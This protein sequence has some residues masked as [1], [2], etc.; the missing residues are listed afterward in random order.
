MHGYVW[1]VFTRRTCSS[2]GITT[3]VFTLVFSHLLFEVSHR[4]L[5]AALGFRLERA[6][7]QLRKGLSPVLQAEN[8]SLHLDHLFILKV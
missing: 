3:S 8:I 5:R 4:Q 1:N 7:R 6:G 2:F